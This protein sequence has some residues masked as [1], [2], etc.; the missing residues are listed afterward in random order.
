MPGFGV[1]VPPEV[2]CPALPCPVR[3]CVNLGSS[4]SPVKSSPRRVLSVQVWEGRE[5]S[6][7]SWKPFHLPVKG[8]TDLES[9]PT[10]NL[11]LNHNVPQ[12]SFQ[13]SSPTS[14]SGFTPAASQ[15][16]TLLPPRAGEGLGV[17]PRPSLRK[18]HGLV[19]L[20]PNWQRPARATAS[21]T[22]CPPADGG[23]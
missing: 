16:S 15:A 14:H 2:L 18:G 4:P 21:A 9:S 22:E 8:T 3:T 13:A 7:G 11:V 17:Q 1:Q 5:G 23:N 12:S 6:L 10:Q 19:L 20:I